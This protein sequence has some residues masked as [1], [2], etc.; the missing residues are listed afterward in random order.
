MTRIEGVSRKLQEFFS[1]ATCMTLGTAL[2]GGPI[3]G[4]PWTHEFGILP[5]G[6]Q[7]TNAAEI[8][9]WIRTSQPSVMAFDG[10]GIS[11]DAGVMDDVIGITL[12]RKAGSFY[13]I[14]NEALNQ[15]SIP[16]MV[17]CDWATLSYQE[18]ISQKE[19]YA[20]AVSL[21]LAGI[22]G[23]VVLGPDYL[24]KVFP[25]TQLKKS[26]PVSPEA[27]KAFLIKSMIALGVVASGTVGFLNLIQ[28]FSVIEANALGECDFNNLVARY[29]D[30]K[31]NE[32]GD[33]FARTVSALYKIKALEKDKWGNIPSKP[34]AMIYGSSHFAIS[35]LAKLADEANNV[36]AVIARLDKSFTREISFALKKLKT[37]E[38]TLGKVYTHL[39]YLRL[40]MARISM[41]TIQKDSETEKIQFVKHPQH[42]ESDMFFPALLG[43]PKRRS[44]TTGREE[45]FKVTL[46]YVMDEILRYQK[47]HPGELSINP[48]ELHRQLSAV[49]RFGDITI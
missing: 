44:E 1:S 34:V 22:L 30:R 46:D 28:A 3:V 39:V 13:E 20:F 31:P 42:P 33:L 27:R 41:S 25:K 23:A 47:Q 24:K 12:S 26:K 35:Q 19:R 48:V 11:T 8:T 32:D 36:E 40:S 7:Y 38:W 14:L 4:L 49:A 37:K 6:L 2:N 29:R 17:G 10:L 9:K 18:S 21:V 5:N 43:N 15:N 45:A 16:T